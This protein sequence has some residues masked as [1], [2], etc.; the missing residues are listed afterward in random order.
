MQLHTIFVVNSKSIVIPLSIGWVTKVYCVVTLFVNMAQ[1]LLYN[2]HSNS[3]I[4]NNRDKYRR[5]WHAQDYIVL[6]VT[7]VTQKLCES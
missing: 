4:A 1:P 3:I 2:E 7:R 6:L 5:V